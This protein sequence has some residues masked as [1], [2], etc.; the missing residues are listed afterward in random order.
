MGRVLEVIGMIDQTLERSPRHA[1]GLHLKVHI[2]ESLPT[3]RAV[4]SAGVEKGA[5]GG[6]R[7]REG[8]WG[9]GAV[10]KC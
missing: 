1:L 2:T 6:N 9:R 4:G 5:G 7:G 3:G 10:G 8:Q